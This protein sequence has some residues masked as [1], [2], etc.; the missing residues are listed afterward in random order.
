MA[1]VILSVVTSL[2]LLLV[3]FICLR[4]EDTVDNMVDLALDLESIISTTTF[5]FSGIFNF[6][7]TI[8]ISLIV[9]K[10]LKKGFEIYILWTDGDPDCDPIGYLTNFARAVVTATC[11]PF[12]YGEIVGI[13]RTFLDESSDKLLSGGYGKISDVVNDAINAGGLSLLYTAF[14][15]LVFMVIFVILLFK[16]TF[17]GI[18]LIILRAGLPF[19]CAGLIDNDKGIFRSYV[20]QFTK[21]FIS[22]VIQILLLKVGLVLL[23]SLDTTDILSVIIGLSFM[24]FS[25]SVPKI[26]NEFMLPQGGGGGISNTVYHSVRVFEIA[27]RAFRG[28]R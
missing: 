26:L 11:F 12:V 23:A 8:G 19:A 18:E 6:I 16:L 13:C 27:G 14:V 25:L 1:I 5:N 9:L 7:Y 15:M 20:N 24:I 3:N 4:I 22:T 21:A 28:G 10:F 17:R 2:I